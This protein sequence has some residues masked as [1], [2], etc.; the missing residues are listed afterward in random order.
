MMFDDLDDIIKTQESGRDTGQNTTQRSG[1]DDWKKKNKKEWLADKNYQPRDIDPDM[2]KRNTNAFTAKGYEVNSAT[3]EIFT[4]LARK[5]DELNYT[6]RAGGDSSNDL[7]NIFS[8]NNRN[9]EYYIPW[10]NFNKVSD[11]TLKQP[12]ETA[13]EIAA[14]VHKLFNEQ[15]PAVKSF[16]AREVHQLL[17]ADLASAVEFLIIYTEDGAEKT[18]ECKRTTGRA[19]FMIRLA[20]KANIPVFNFKNEQSILRFKS[21]LTD[22]ITNR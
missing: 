22:L 18:R 5:L 15:K 19:S 7:E 17:G 1:G 9:T 3:K 21:Y 4:E 13:Y 20:D 8:N 10:G 2:L 11:A 6:F 16:F 14:G 12:T